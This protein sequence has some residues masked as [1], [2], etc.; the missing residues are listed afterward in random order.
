M[1]AVELPDKGHARHR[2]S[3]VCAPWRRC[4]AGLVWDIFSRISARCL[5][6]FPI[7]VWYISVTANG[8]W[9]NNNLQQE[10]IYDMML[11]EHVL[12]LFSASYQEITSSRSEIQHWAFNLQSWVTAEKLRQSIQ[13]HLHLHQRKSLPESA[14]THIYLT[15]SPINILTFSFKWALFELISLLC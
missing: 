9:N 13:T 8:R 10:D 5:L 4:G 12:A 2:W 7:S 1:E 11:Y 14:E 15:N 6:M 3:W